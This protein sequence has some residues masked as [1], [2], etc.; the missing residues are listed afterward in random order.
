M[1]A[2]KYKNISVAVLALLGLLVG[3]GVFYSTEKRQIRACAEDVKTILND[4]GSLEILET[5]AFNATDGTP[6]IK[7]QYTAKNKLGGR[8][9]D[10][11]ICGFKKEDPVVLNPDDI[12]NQDRFVARILAR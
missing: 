7:L 11:A 6:R 3:L 2:K 1:I 10:E 5:E 8:V 12:F 4:P 9:R